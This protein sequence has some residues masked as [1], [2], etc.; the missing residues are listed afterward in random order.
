MNDSKSDPM[1]TEKDWDAYWHGTAGVSAYSS[2]G[3]SHP[4]IKAFWM[5]FFQQTKG[6]ITE[7]EMIDIASGNGAIIDYALEVFETNPI[8][9]SCIDISESAI[10]NIRE[11]FPSVH[12]VVSDAR[13]I[14]MDSGRFDIVSSQFGVEYAGLEAIDEAVRLLAEGGQL[15][16]LLHSRNGS[17]YDEC[18]TNLDAISRVQECGFVPLAIEMFR[19]GFA[20]VRGADRAPYDAAATQLAPAVAILEGIMRK[21]GEHVADDTIVRLYN[22]V[23][24][25]HSEIVQYDADEILHWLSQMSGELET[26]A[27]RMSS[28]CQ[29]AIDR[30]SFE[31]ICDGLSARQCKIQLAGPLLAPGDELPLAWALKVSR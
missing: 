10:G 4:A 20:A 23:G 16:L 12:C 25:I 24:R 13:S 15:A 30:A 19:T 28:M 9:I 8:N 18:A 7:P 26:Y 6:S 21:H 14:P 1:R 5:D 27:G 11:R 17:I 31:K 3:V 22:D 2:G 29:S